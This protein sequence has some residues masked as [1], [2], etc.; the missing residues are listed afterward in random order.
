MNKAEERALRHKVMRIAS[1]AMEERLLSQIFMML[2]LTGLAL[3]LAQ[4]R[5]IGGLRVPE[6]WKPRYQSLS[7]AEAARRPQY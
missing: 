2:I 5:K 6:L 4:G 3:A 7:Y 1:D